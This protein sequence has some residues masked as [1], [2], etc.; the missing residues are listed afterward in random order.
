[1]DKSHHGGLSNRVKHHATHDARSD[2]FSSRGFRSPGSTRIATEPVDQHRRKLLSNR[3]HSRLWESSVFPACNIHE[4]QRLQPESLEQL[5]LAKSSTRRTPFKTC[6]RAML[7]LRSQ[8]LLAWS[9]DS[10][11]RKSRRSYGRKSRTRRTDKSICC[12]CQWQSRP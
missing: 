1:M 12:L 5:F 9:I 7:S 11:P 10:T 6:R 2:R 8:E 4:L 3:V